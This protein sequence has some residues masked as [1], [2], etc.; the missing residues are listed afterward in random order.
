[1]GVVYVINQPNHSSGGG[2]GECVCVC[3]CVWVTEVL[4]TNIL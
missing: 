4:L 2:G 3:V 1:M